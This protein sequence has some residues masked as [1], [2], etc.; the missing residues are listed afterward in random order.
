MNVIDHTTQ[1]PE[2]FG[3]LIGYKKL[4]ITS[5]THV[6]EPISEAK[7]YIIKCLLPNELQNLNGYASIQ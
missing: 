5:W 2:E 3:E 4:D 7:R 6:N 1:T